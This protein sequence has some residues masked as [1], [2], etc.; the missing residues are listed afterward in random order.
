[1][2][3]GQATNSLRHTSLNIKRNVLAPINEK[4]KE[5]WSD[6]RQG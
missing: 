6:F 3:V 2:D 4:S 1:M 5:K